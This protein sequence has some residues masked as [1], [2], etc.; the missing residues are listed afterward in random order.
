M[1]DKCFKTMLKNELATSGIVAARA[2]CVTLC[3]THTCA[4][5]T[6][7]VCT[8]H[9]QSMRTV[10]A[11]IRKQALWLMGMAFKCFNNINQA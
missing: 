9:V 7:G 5:T 6:H 4:C 8:I 2:V 3:R 1:H 11:L 10:G